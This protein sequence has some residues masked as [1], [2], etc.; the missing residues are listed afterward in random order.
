MSVPFDYATA[1]QASAQRQ[2]PT[3]FQ[4]FG[5]PQ[6]AAPPA[7]PPMAAPAG[8]PPMDAMG[9]PAPAAAPTGL[10]KYPDYLKALEAK[11]G[12]RLTRPE[13]ELAQEKFRVGQFIP[14]KLQ[15]GVKQFELEPYA[16]MFDQRAAEIN[17]EYL[18]Q[19]GGNGEP[20]PSPDDPMTVGRV[21]AGAKDIAVHGARGIFGIVPGIANILDYAYRYGPLGRAVNASKQLAEG[22]LP[23]MELSAEGVKDRLRFVGGDTRTPLG[24][25]AAWLSNA[26]D[27]GRDYVLSERELQ[28][29]K[30]RAG[31]LAG[32]DAPFAES[33]SKYVG[34][35]LSRPTL[36]AGDLANVIGSL[37]G[38]TP[39]ARGAAAVMAK[40]TSRLDKITKAFIPATIIGTPQA[41]NAASMIE[42]KIYK[43]PFAELLE[44]EE[45]KF[46][47]DTAVKD[48]GLSPAAAEE[49]VRDEVARATMPTVLAAELVANVGLAA[50]PGLGFAERSLAGTAKAGGRR[51]L[52]A[53]RGFGS[54]AVEES[55]AGTIEQA[56]E[57][58]AE[59]TSTGASHSLLR[60]AGQAV[61][62]GTILGGL[63]GGAIGAMTPNDA[64]VAPIVPPPAPAPAPVAGTPAPVVAPVPAP[65]PVAGPGL[66]STAF[67]PALSGLRTKVITALATK[68]ATGKGL[69]SIKTAAEAVAAARTY[70]AATLG[71][72]WAQ[73]DPAQQS[74]AVEAVALEIGKDKPYVADIPP[75]VAG[76]APVVAP[77]PAAPVVNAV[78]I[79]AGAIG[80]APAPAPVV[81]TPPPV[82][83]APIPA[84]PAPAPVGVMG[85]DGNPLPLTPPAPVAAAAEPV[86]EPEEPQFQPLPATLRKASPNY[87][88]GGTN[89]GVD[90]ES[91]VEK[92]L[93]IV[94]DGTKK[95]AADAKYLKWIKDNL[96]MTEDEA[97]AAGQRVAAYLKGLAATAASGQKR[98]VVPSG[99]AEAAPNA[100]PAIPLVPIAAPEVEPVAAPAEATKPLRAKRIPK[101]PTEKKPKVP[102]PPKTA[103]PVPAQPT[104]GAQAVPASAPSATNSPARETAEAAIQRIFKGEV[105]D[106]WATE[107][108]EAINLAREGDTSL[109][110]HYLKGDNLAVGDASGTVRGP[111]AAERRAVREAA[112]SLKPGERG[113]TVVPY[114]EREVIET[115]EEGAARV[116]AALVGKNALEV[117]QWAA[118]NGPN[119]AYRAIARAVAGTMKK[120]Q[121]RG[122]AFSIVVGPKKKGNQGTTISNWIASG[123]MSKGLPGGMAV[124][125]AFASNQTEGTAFSTILHEYIHAVS[126]T[127][128]E[129]VLEPKKHSMLRV[130]GSAVESA[131]LDLSEL[132]RVIMD[133]VRAKLASGEDVSDFLERA[134]RGS[135]ILPKEVG[136]VSNNAFLDI[137]EI[138]AWGLS[139]PRFQEYLKQLSIDPARF[140]KKN[141]F[142]KLIDIVRR[143]LDLPVQYESAL[144]RLLDIGETLLAEPTVDEWL[145]NIFGADSATGVNIASKI[146][147]ARI[148]SDNPHAKQE[149]IFELDEPKTRNKE[150]THPVPVS[151]LQRIG[152]VF[153]NATY[154]LERAVQEVIKLGGTVA[155]DISPY[156]AGRLFSGHVA[157]LAALDREEITNPLAAWIKQNF[158]K[159]ADTVEEF[160]TY[161]DQFLQ[162][163]HELTERIPD[164]W[165]QRVPLLNGMNVARD[166]LIDQADNGEITPQEFYKQLSNLVNQNASVG[167]EEWSKTTGNVKE[168]SELRRLLAALSAKGYNAQT[169]AEYNA[170]FDAAR[171]RLQEH[172]LASGRISPN[173]PWVRARDWKWY[174]PLK[175]QQDVDEDVAD[176]DYGSFGGKAREF[177]SIAVNLAEGRKTFAGSVASQLIADMNNESY[178]HAE[179]K[180][181]EALFSFVQENL[182]NMGDTAIT[183]VQGTLRSGFYRE[184]TVKGKVVQK[185]VSAKTVYKEPKYGFVFHN[186]DTHFIVDLDPTNIIAGNLD[187]GVKGFRVA[188]SPT[189]ILKGLG[190]I[191]NIMSRSFTTWSPQWQFSVGFLRD[192]NYIPLT[193]AMEMFTNPLDAGK[194]AMGYTKRLM[195]NFLKSGTL[196]LGD[197]IKQVWGG[198]SGKG[199]RAKAM[200]DPDA[201][202]GQLY[203]YHAAG[204]STHFNQGLNPDLAYDELFGFAERGGVVGK[205]GMTYDKWNEVTGNWAQLLENVGR[206]AAFSTMVQD[207]GM[208]PEEA[209]ARVK[210]V[211]DF[212]QTGEWGRKINAWLAFYRVGATG[213]DVM[214]RVFTTP[215]GGF[216]WRKFRNWSSFMAVGASSALYLL[217]MA[218]G[219]DEDGVPKIKK[220]DINT[221]TQR[222]VLPSGETY[223]I[224]LGL[225][226]LMAAPGIIGTMLG[227]GHITPT[228]AT[229]AM[230]EVVTRNTP[231]QPAGWGKDSGPF[232]FATSWIQGILVPTAGK[233]FVEVATNVNAFDSM[234]HTTQKNE[235]KFRSNSGMQVTPQEW[236]DLATW[237][238]EVTRGMVDIYPEDYRHMAK[239]YGG[240]IASEA[241][242]QLSDYEAQEDVGMET[243]PVRTSALRQPNDEQYYYARELKKTKT[244]LM[245][246][247]RRFNA[248]EDA[249]T[250]QEFNRDPANKR[251]LAAL[252]QLESAQKKYYDSLNA[253]RESNISPQGKR[254]R[255]KLA[256]SA[257]RRAVE[258]AQGALE[259]R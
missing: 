144:E 45:N 30:E 203:A 199:L 165:M 59:N 196:G 34:A 154:G 219:D 51:G 115:T 11:T 135:G 61:G 65:M 237:M 127:M 164:Q 46:L 220:W 93:Y 54:E 92:A 222:M 145:S 210:G 58:I 111:N 86:V 40:G 192:T 174:F 24:E 169:M 245:N 259:T 53:A 82:A 146:I 84:P 161:S 181:K 160:H 209:A 158:R 87:G 76:L 90:F 77:A 110:D 257:L 89:F 88:Y 240:Q 19:A 153:A 243:N 5:L 60:G 147:L 26:A 121:D 17:E 104:T 114:E 68:G 28:S 163:H 200:Q 212:G 2:Y 216:D 130:K 100:A 239:G 211:M 10:P 7:L 186:G 105:T 213:V 247:R 177:R 140:S 159:F 48:Y 78:P 254:D 113:E 98:L 71:P 258:S 139:E 229:N 126:M 157:E 201:F 63:A 97:R 141:A 148:E 32:P 103:A 14:I 44:S 29:R 1:A 151:K 132:R 244:A 91:D 183:M 250:L 224:G 16:A 56:G 155:S 235:G 249:G 236:K 256:D 55:A 31:E 242:R 178:K 167:L 198:G 41:A 241:I 138:L 109:L 214:R 182:A 248:A 194:F 49:M 117:I 12:R 204:G 227:M 74:A 134:A 188:Q 62:E 133:D 176:T 197:S 191:T 50:I 238:H 36:L 112:R 123:I 223:P 64:P 149:G 162:A 231:V 217:A 230:Y 106:S 107:L 150:D 202:L 15:Q 193:L 33:F 66:S 225:P 18:A 43:R 207:L 168:L 255:R 173:D 22:G 187:K 137:D 128:I 253:I 118:E 156:F 13:L 52:R 122:A 72:A 35:T 246:T 234:I 205:L 172:M 95:S 189:G 20:P 175:G 9:L 171:A 85:P 73:M 4:D 233:P 129:S 116:K 101:P 120:L 27:E 8:A 39:L 6:R 252:K 99:A 125:V 21:A 42:D 94:R 152:E 47:Y 23:S 25:G 190:V 166:L 142:S 185:P 81:A 75:L 195:G 170:Q 96:E 179:R 208:A 102:P 57:N 119:P 184:V 38:P 228:E 3:S 180:F 251:R 69:K 79:P 131:V 226:Q 206:V 67:A 215:K 136:K 83:A 232:G 37:L 108:A 80:P 218:L 143:F 221:L 124:R 70:A